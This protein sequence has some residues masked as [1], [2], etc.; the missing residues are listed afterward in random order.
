[1]SSLNDW[2]IKFLNIQ[3]GDM[4]DSEY[5]ALKGYTSISR[6]K[7][8]NERDGSSQKYLEGFIHDYNPSLE[9]GTAVHAAILSQ[10]EFEVSNY[11]GKPSGKLGYFVER[12]YHWRKEGKSCLEAI[13]L[14]SDDSNYYKGKITPKILRNALEKGFDYYCK[15]STGYFNSDKEVI[16]LSKQMLDNYKECVNS[17]NNS[18]SIQKILKQND[19][20]EKQ[21]FNEIAMFSDI[22]VTFPDGQKHIIKVKG[23]LDS[24]V[25]DPESEILYLN[26]VKTTSKQ[27]EYFM[28]KYIDGQC[29]DGVFEHHYYM[30]QL[31]LYGIMLQKYFQEILHIDYRDLQ[32]NIFA[33]ETVN[34]HRADVFRINNS[35]I[36]LGYKLVKEWICKLAYYE[37]YGFDKKFPV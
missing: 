7:L 2:K 34:Q 5:F 14:A 22:E 13:S 30:A 25:W 29:Y 33:V 10:N 27:L 9:L 28:G 37:K 32:C 15:L 35:Y 31:S 3:G 16:V 21:F 20:E 19:F 26:D 24:V 18:Y 1:M 6:L 12:V 23:K 11:E 17:I 36:D 4:P 8:L